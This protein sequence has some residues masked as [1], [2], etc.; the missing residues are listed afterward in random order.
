M[1]IRTLCKEDLKSSLQ[2]VLMTN[3]S[4]INFFGEIF[5]KEVNLAA[6]GYRETV[7]VWCRDTV[8]GG[9]G[10]Y[11]RLSV[12]PQKHVQNNVNACLSHTPQ[13]N[14]EKAML[15]AC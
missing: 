3:S 14:S 4:Q 11:V 5:T 15:L 13:T 6:T 7:F 12:R 8:L 2:S 10:T 9:G 1:G